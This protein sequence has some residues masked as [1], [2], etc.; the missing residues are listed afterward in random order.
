M[1]RHNGDYYCLNRFHAFGIKDKLEFCQ[2]VVYS[3]DTKTLRFNQNRKS[4]TSTLIIY[5]DCEV[6]QKRFMYTKLTEKHHLQKRK[7]NI[8]RQVFSFFII[9]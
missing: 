2:V 3:E 6:L 1:S 4:D 9:S 7:M 8:F 5:A